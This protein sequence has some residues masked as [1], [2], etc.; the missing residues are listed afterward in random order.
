MLV[1]FAS[2]CTTPPMEAAEEAYDYNSIYPI[3]K[4]VTGPDV[5][6]QG[7]HYEFTATIRG[8]STYAWESA[9]GAEI[10]SIEEVESNWK[11]YVHFPIAITTEDAPEV[12]SV[13]ETTMGGIQSDP[14]TYQIDSITAFTALPIVGSDNVN[15]GFSASYKVEPSA[16]DKMFS[17]YSWGASAG[18]VSSSAA[19]PWSADIFFS[20]EDVGEV[21]VYL[22]EQT[23]SG[24][25]DTSFLDVVVNE[26]CPLDAGIADLVGSWTGDDA[27]YES[28]ITT[29]VEDDAHLAVTGM[30]VNFIQDWWAEEVIDGGTISMQV[31]EDGT[32]VIP[33][34]YIYTTEYDGAPYDYEIEGEGRWNNCGENPTLLITYDIYYA[35]ED[36][37]LAATYSPAYLPTPYLTAD[38][39][40]DNNKSAQLFFDKIDLKRPPK[41]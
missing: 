17:T 2:S 35:G 16:L 15:G 13:T 29:A 20:N 8:G 6:M 9:R 11:T 39:V 37:G 10:V 33:R 3:V 22:V 41:N 32:V 18:E 27:F 38:V 26:Y 34:Q 5:P 7:R 1:F 36:V 21:E 19:T 12:I 31:N 24:M 30:S 40:L 25:K 14:A 23:S 28:I 4:D